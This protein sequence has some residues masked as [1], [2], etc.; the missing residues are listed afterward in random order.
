MSLSLAPSRRDVLQ[1]LAG[2]A[3]AA[4][5]PSAPSLALAPASDARRLDV[6]HHYVSPAWMAALDKRFSASR[7]TDLAT[8]RKYS[9]SAALEAMD[10]GGIATAVL[11]TTEPGVWF[12]N[13][14][15][16]SALARDMNEYGA[17]LAAD[18]K[19]RFGLFAVLP[20]PNVEA[21][22]REAEYALDTLKADGIGVLS[23]YDARWLGD[24]SFAPL[25]D[26]LNRRKAVVFSHATAPGCCRGLMPNIDPHTIELNTDTSRTIVSLIESG[27]AA[28]F[29]DIR[30][31]FSHAGGT[32]PSLAGR[33]FRMQATAAK[34]AAPAEPNSRLDHL[35][36]FYYDTAGSANPIQMTSL[37]M[38]VSASQIL[39]GTD[40][41]WGDPARIAEGLG[42]CGFTTEELRGIA[43]D[44]AA[45]LL[46]KYQI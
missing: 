40:F 13:D 26:E 31:I 29:P 8:F 2:L 17:R 23:S 35:R 10:K 41:P 19:G 39:F 43:R 1:G 18:H 25:W 3:A 36:R 11:S 46:P 44:N 12:G 7:F 42:D 9:P 15:Q 38:I 20:L 5:V 33:Y 24:P 22:L 37:K 16:A 30:F 27:T 4:A 45:R 6:H 21:S 34:L 14:K 28:R 32:I